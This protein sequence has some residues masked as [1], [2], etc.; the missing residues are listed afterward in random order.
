MI[1]NIINEKYIK[2]INSNSKSE[3]IQLSMEKLEA[4]Q[5][6]DLKKLTIEFK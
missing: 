1:D 3:K 5:K 4:L 6:L 2:Y